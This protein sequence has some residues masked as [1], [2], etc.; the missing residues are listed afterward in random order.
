MPE[1]WVAL[2]VIGCQPEAQDDPTQAEEQVTILGIGTGEQA[3]IIHDDDG[4]AR[5]KRGAHQNREPIRAV[6]F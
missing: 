2:F 4:K 6:F 5:T 3:E 1:R